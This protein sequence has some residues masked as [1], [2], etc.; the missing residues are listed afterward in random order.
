MGG[1]GVVGSGRPSAVSQNPAE[2]VRLEQY[3]A[4]LFTS[5][6][7]GLIRANYLGGVLPLSERRAFGV[8]WLRVDY[9]DDELAYAQNR[10]RLDYAFRPA[11][12]LSLG[13]G[14]NYRTA[15]ASLDGTVLGSAAGWSTDVGLVWNAPL[16]EGLTTGVGVRNWYSATSGGRWRPGAW[17]RVEDG[18]S[19][20]AA[21][22]VVTFGAQYERTRFVVATEFGDDWKLGVEARLSRRLWLRSGVSVPRKDA[23]TLTFGVSGSWRAGTLDYAFVMPPTLEPTSYFGLTFGWSY[24]I[25]PV[26]IEGV[27]LANLYPAL[28]EFYA[29]GDGRVRETPYASPSDAQP[30]TNERVGEVWLYNPGDESV[31]VSVRLRLERFT[32]RR[33]TEAVESVEIPARSRIVVPLRKALLN[34]A[35]IELTENRPVEVRVEV[36]DVRNEARR[37]AVASANTLLY[38]RNAIRLDDIGKLAV[39]VTPTND[40][41]RG[42]AERTLH[43]ADEAIRNSSLPTSLIRAA[44]LFAALSD[45][46][47]GRDPNLPRESGTVDAIRYPAELLDRFLSHAN[48]DRPVGDCDDSTVL[49]CALLESVG[50]STAFLQTP[51]HVLMAFDPGGMTLEEAQERGWD[52]Y[53]IPIDGYAWVPLE[54][55]SLDKGFAVAWREGL[56]QVR[57]GVLNSIT[58]R[59]AWE[60]YG[61]VNPELSRQRVTVSRDVLL[62]RLAD[63]ESD[64][65]F[66]EATRSWRKNE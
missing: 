38:S 22:R 31:R 42:F 61:N 9:E 47:Y 39:F 25:P 14:V 27:A 43:E 34:D 2:V 64:A 7:Y 8:D 4:E 48:G 45:V 35:S 1:V 15:R 33:G 28:R 32:S 17:I 51:G 6:L 41:V 12:S 60:R 54:T 24:R 46:T 62:S 57:L 37:R 36:A 23:A 53:T 16:V 5:T 55:T 3:A 30:T 50:I 18:P 56:E 66:V 21:P 11:T 40:V 58:T 63:M 13:V 19:Q 26:V 52:A 49:V 44:T 65:W 10:L 59:L 20:R 29:R